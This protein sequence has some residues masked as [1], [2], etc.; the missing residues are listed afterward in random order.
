MKMAGLD[1]NH[2]VKKDPER[3]PLDALSLKCPF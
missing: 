1:M 3:K 2:V